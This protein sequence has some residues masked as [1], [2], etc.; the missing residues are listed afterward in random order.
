M[1]ANEVEL[2]G[3]IVGADG[4]RPSPDKVEKV[5]TYPEP[6]TINQLRRYLGLLNFYRRFIPKAADRLL[7]LTN[8]LAGHKKKKNAPIDLPP[9]AS[10][11][12]VVSREI[13][14]EASLLTY[15]HADAPLS[16]MTD[17]SDAALGAALHQTVEGKTIPLGFFAQKLSPTEQRYNTFGRELLAIYRAIRH[18]SHSLEG[19]EFA[20]FTDHK[21]LSFAIRSNSTQHAPRECRHLDFISQFTTDIR[22]VSGPMN[23]VA[24]AL[25]RLEVEAISENSTVDYNTLAAAQQSDEDL[26]RLRNDPNSGLQLRA[27]PLPD[28]AGEVWCDVT[29]NTQR[30]FVPETLR[31]RVFQSLHN[32]SHPGVK[33]TVE[34]VSARFVWPNMKREL[35]EWAQNC[36]Q[37]QR[38][39]VTRHTKSPIGTFA[40]PDARFSHVHIDIVGPLPVC[41]GYSYL[42]T[43]ID[44]FTRWPEAVPIKD[45]SAETICR[46]FVSR[47]VSVFGV[48]AVVTTDRG[49]QFEADLFQSLARTLGTHRI[50]TT[51]Y[52]PVANGM[53]ERMHRTLKAALMA[54]DDS[55]NW[56]DCLPIVLLGM[57]SSLKEPLGCSTAE[58]VFGTT[59]KLPCKFVSPSPNARTPR[60]VTCE[61]SKQT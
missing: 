15:F 32:L 51:A 5:R 60:G 30:P 58:L 8:L 59:L 44:R 23:E 43:M 27:I 20:V 39:K 4:I 28:G 17:A 61:N 1:G 31:R 38:A 56:V 48:P 49:T 36:Q 41:Q 47:W 12:F 33:A 18:F 21:P 13:L 54:H 25:S 37:C 55:G 40:Q 53:V 22:H 45:I 16:L 6:K 9:D 26:E 24:D 29:N 14:S 2:L 46:A 52:H 11:A 35:K 50:H 42:L 57:R 10:D 7:P 34:L 3:H 19:R